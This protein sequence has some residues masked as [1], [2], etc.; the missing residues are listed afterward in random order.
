VDTTSFHTYNYALTKLK[1]KIELGCH[2]FCHISYFKTICLVTYFFLSTIILLFVMFLHRT[3][4]SQLSSCYF[5]VFFKEWAVTG[6]AKSGPGE[7]LP[8]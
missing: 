4:L 5:G 1:N 3:Q 2:S 7:P 8:T 6:G